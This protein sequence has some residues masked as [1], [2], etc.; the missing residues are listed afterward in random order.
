VPPVIAFARRDGT[1]LDAVAQLLGRIQERLNVAEASDGQVPVV[2]AGER[3]EQRYAF[4][5]EEIRQR[6][7]VDHGSVDAGILVD[8]ASDPGDSLVPELLRA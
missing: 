6:V 8:H 5:A 3:P 1:R 2:R 7:L 4:Q